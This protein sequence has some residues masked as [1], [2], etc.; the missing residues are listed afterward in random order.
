MSSF[1][2]ALSGGAAKKDE[3]PEAEEQEKEGEAS[4]NP[5]SKALGKLFD[6]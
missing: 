4:E 6:K 1:L 3:S 5:I 2:G